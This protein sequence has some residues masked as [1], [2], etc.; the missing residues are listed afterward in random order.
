MKLKFKNWNEVNIKTY[1]SLMSVADEENEIDAEI[2]I[3]SILCGVDE[4]EIL[5]LQISEYQ[6]L[7][8]EA[9]W[10]A[11]KPVVKAYA[12][13]TMKINKK[14]YDVYSDVSKITT[15]QY[16]DFQSYLKQN[17][18]DRYLSYILACFIVPKGKQYGE[19]PIDEVVKEIEE[20]VSVY[21]AQCMF[22]FFIVEYLTLTKIIVR[23]LESK[24]NNQEVQ[25]KLKEIHS[26]LGGD[27][28][29]T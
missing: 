14:K 11:D 15:A 17:K 18:L 29:A 8:A 26:L 21:D 10:I 5:N 9:Q 13:K 20:Y 2:K 4:E 7:R 27:G 1:K 22:F 3:L 12:P 25:K 19:V 24:T 6:E 23:S 16:I 28:L